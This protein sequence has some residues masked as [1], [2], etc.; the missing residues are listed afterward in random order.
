MQHQASTLV[1]PKSN[2]D[3]WFTV[4]TSQSE[5]TNHHY[6]VKVYEA[7]KNGVSQRLLAIRKIKHDNPFTAIR[8]ANKAHMEF[9]GEVQRGEF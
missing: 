9:V 4:V 5:D 8:L 3:Q 2:K 7:D 6:F 1:K